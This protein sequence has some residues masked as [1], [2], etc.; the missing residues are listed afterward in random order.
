MT[1]SATRMA[2]SISPGLRPGGSPQSGGLMDGTNIHWRSTLIAV[3]CV[4][5]LLV[6]TT[7]AGCCCCKPKTP[8]T[9][10][11][12][13]RL[14]TDPMDVVIAKIN[15]NAIAVPSL[16]TQLDYSATVV[17]PEKKTTDHFAGDGILLFTRPG[18]LLMV[19]NKDV[20]GRVFELG[21]NDLQFWVKM[22]TGANDWE[23][24][25]GNNA[26][27][28]KPCCLPVPI[29][30][31]ALV[32]V[33]GVSVYGSDFL[34]QPVPVMR[35]DPDA[36]AYVFNFNQRLLDRWVT[37]KEVWYDAGS[38]LPTRVLLYN[39]IG[40]PMLVAKLSQHRPIDVP[41]GEKV[42]GPVVA[43]NYD[44]TFPLTGSMMSITFTNPATRR[45]Q[46]KLSLPNASSFNRPDPDSNNNVIQVDKA[47]AGE[48]T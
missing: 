32:E 27:L 6:A 38:C 29:D 43:W 31:A 35:Y 22:R 39:A 47:C 21:V 1:K 5:L 36:D 25:W 20:A 10:P 42:Q 24:R 16:W 7:I 28:G 4:S 15:H 13:I 26:N 17:N 11:T 12:T 37:V 23:Y 18:S 48:G 45:E 33:L 2:A 44:L 40:R 41:G 9:K 34:Q 3:R 30:P 8:P 46:G 14:V 19:G